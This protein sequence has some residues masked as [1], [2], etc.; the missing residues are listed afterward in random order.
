[1][2]APKGNQFALGNNG[3]RPSKYSEEILTKT[4]QYID[5]CGT[6]NRTLVTIQGLA[7][8]LKVNVD[9][10]SEWKKT[11]YEFSES[12]DKLMNKQ[13]QQLIND[14]IYGGKEVNATIVKLM[15]MNNHG[16]REK[17]ET[18]ITTQGEKVEPTNI[19]NIDLQDRIKQLKGE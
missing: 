16:M 4:Y 1:M 9:T 7:L 19:I 5:S 10:I 13:A 11:Y 12:I 14:G 15:L 2:G 18:D 17:S 6:E 3:G 8:Y